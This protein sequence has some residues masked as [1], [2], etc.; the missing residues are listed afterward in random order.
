VNRI[1]PTPIERQGNVSKG[2]HQE[3]DTPIRPGFS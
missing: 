3:E 1:R 2:D